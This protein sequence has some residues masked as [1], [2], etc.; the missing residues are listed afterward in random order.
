[1]RSVM[2]H[3]ALA[4]TEGSRSGAARL[5]DVSRQAVQQIL[6]GAESPAE[7]KDLAPAAG[8]PAAPTS[9]APGDD[10]EKGDAPRK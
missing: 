1:M 8:E 5:L 4:L 10:L 9:V 6:R 7:M 2:L 3:Q